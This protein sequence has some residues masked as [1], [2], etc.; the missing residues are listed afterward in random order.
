MTMTKPHP[1]PKDKKGG[2]ITA[3]HDADRLRKEKADELTTDDLNKVV[4]GADAG[5][6]VATGTRSHKPI[7]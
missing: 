3:D 6:G 7:S 5:S 4:G 2:R 1:N